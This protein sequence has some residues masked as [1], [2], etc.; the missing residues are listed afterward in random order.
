[1]RIARSTD[2]KSDDWCTPEWI[3][4]L[5]GQWDLD[6][7]SNPRSNIRALASYCLERGQNGLKLPWRGSV[8]CNPP[9][10]APLPFAQLLAAHDD[11]WCALV[12]L[13]PTT[14]W[15]AVLAEACDDWAP[16]RFRLRFERSDRKSITPNFMSAL[17]WR[18]WEPCVDLQR[19]LWMRRGRPAP[20]DASTV[21]KAA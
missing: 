9:Y 5:V 2:E 19:Q 11:A 10:S 16:F 8:W 21:A 12:K 14:A 17:I 4:E 18:R 13:D 15:W 20:R 7:A 1:M 6:P 3:A